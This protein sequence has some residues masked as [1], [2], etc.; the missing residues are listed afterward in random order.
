MQ[1]FYFK[2][3][4]S[5]IK[6]PKRE[7]INTT[8]ALKILLFGT[9][10]SLILFSFLLDSPVNIFLGLIKQVFHP[11]GLITDYTVVSG[12][13]ATFF[14][15]GLLMLISLLLFHLTKITLSGP[16]IACSFLMAGFAMFGKNIANIW[17]IIFGVWIVSRIQ[18][19]SFSQYIYIALYG[20]ALSPLITEV[21][22]TID[23]PV[24]K[25]VVVIAVGILIGVTLVPLSSYGLRV[26]Q[27]YNLYN[28]G[29]S[30]GLIGTMLV[31]VMKSFGY[32]K[33]TTLV[34]NFEN[35]QLVI[36]FLYGLFLFFILAG[37]YFGG[38]WK[39]Y[40]HL[41]RHSGRLMA[42][43]IVMDSPAVVL[44]NMGC[45]GILGVTYILVIGGNING[46][47]I[48]AILTVVGFGAFGKHLRNV[49]P[50]I[51]GV[52]LG[53][54]IKMWNINDPNIQLAAL[55]GTALAPISGQFGWPYGILAGF[56]HSSMV[57]NIG[58]FHGGLNL[59]NNGFSAGLVALILVPI[60]EAF[61]V[62]VRG[63]KNEKK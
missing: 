63:G 3:D 6:L 10:A 57:L 29:F 26:H 9:A 12:Y 13:G 32:N 17:P 58:V 18:K 37:I 19:E 31:S 55:F 2:K 15:A 36:F 38:T 49:I 8:Q 24:A 50:V 42:D 14:N 5:I 53:S 61:Q 44:I 51:A 4:V 59:Y 41:F 27:G 22:L 47:T 1:S 60:I 23:H 11:D 33:E 40:K 46:P 16:S 54:L 43:F 56:V 34:W 20:T 28:V 52:V 48:G 62:R 25:V 21:A 7:I 45:L 39:N 30:A 35:N